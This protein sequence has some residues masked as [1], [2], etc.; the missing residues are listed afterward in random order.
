MLLPERNTLCP[1]VMAN[2]YT[3][4]SAVQSMVVNMLGVSF[5]GL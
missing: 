1:N 2:E 5:V 4:A 3:N